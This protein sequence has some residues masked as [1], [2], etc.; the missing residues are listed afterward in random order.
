MTAAKR[1]LSESR[2]S[3]NYAPRV[4]KKTPHG[5]GFKL[6]DL[7]GAMERLFSDGKIRMQDYGRQSALRHRIVRVETE[8]DQ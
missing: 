3:G 6:N 4:I 2:H 5:K 1:P 8:D 7:V